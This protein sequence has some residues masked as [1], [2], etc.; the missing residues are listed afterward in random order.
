MSFYKAVG[1][2]V[3]NFALN[4]MSDWCGANSTFTKNFLG[5]LMYGFKFGKKVYHS[6][7]TISTHVSHSVKRYQLAAVFGGKC[8]NVVHLGSY[9]YQQH[10]IYNV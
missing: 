3:D 1:K 10:L 2:L 8:T 9:L 4:Q 6:G 5:L 7:S